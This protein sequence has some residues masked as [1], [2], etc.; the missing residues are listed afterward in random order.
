LSPHTGAAA[1][2]HRLTR[3]SCLQFSF[4]SRSLH[5]TGPDRSTT[6]VASASNTQ[7]VPLDDSVM[8][9]AQEDSQTSNTISTS[10]VISSTFACVAFPLTVS[11]LGYLS[12]TPAR[13]LLSFSSPFP[14]S[15]LICLLIEKQTQKATHKPAPFLSLRHEQSHVEKRARSSHVNKPALPF[16]PASFSPQL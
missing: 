4:R 3:A 5:T 13:S 10:S 16:S 7:H 9:E 14:F 12:M 2:H 11:S 15:W 8:E 6:P 1:I